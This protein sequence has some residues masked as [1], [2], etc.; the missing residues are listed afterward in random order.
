MNKRRLGRSD[1]EVAPLI[2]GGHVFGWT[3]DEAASFRLLDHFVD[4]GFNFI[5]TAD[6]YGRY[7]VGQA[8]LSETV[9]GRW[10]KL[11]GKRSQ[12]LIGTKVGGLMAAGQ[13]GLSRAH[14]LASADGSLQRLNA[15]HI[16]LY[17]SHFDDPDIPQEET[18]AAYAQ[19]IQEGKVRAI[20][21]S[22]LTAE[23]LAGA[24]ATSDRLHLPRYES[25]Q[26]QYNLCERAAFEKDLEPLCR[27]KNLGV[28]SYSP[29]ACG[30]LTGKYRGE[31]DLDAAKRGSD[32][33]KFF[34]ER[35]TRILAALNEVAARLRASPAQ[36]AIAW[37]LA[38]PAVTAPVTSATSVAQLDSLIAATRLSLDA[39]AIGRLDQASA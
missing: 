6:I 21:A 11:G 18:L 28:I 31:S 16:D 30:F 26:P 15:D 38:R 3:V 2:L 14:I 19:L 37:L 39:E 35:G 29:L 17:Q 13:K 4:E 7:W 23:R 9:I 33:R 27:E 12:V 36:V 24:L 34:N 8:G 1:L 22:N 10:L 5:D 25:L 32:V 20:G